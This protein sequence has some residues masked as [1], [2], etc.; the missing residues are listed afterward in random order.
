MK[1]LIWLAVMVGGA[2]LICQ[3]QQLWGTQVPLGSA[4]TVPTFVATM[5]LLAIALLLAWLVRVLIAWFAALVGAS[6]LG[7]WLICE[8]QRLWGVQVPVPWDEHASVS[9]FEA[10]MVVLLAGGLLLVVL[11]M[12]LRV[13]LRL[14]FLG[15]AR[16]RYLSA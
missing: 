12:L 8:E 3:H 11:A 7:A 2:A 10:T 1:F 14:A 5:V 9:A 16:N 15:W 4:Y 6:A 13:R